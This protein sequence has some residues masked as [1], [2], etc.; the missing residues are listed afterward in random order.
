MLS[1]M[2]PWDPQ[3]YLEETRRENRS[4]QVQELALTPEQRWDLYTFVEW[5]ARPENM[6][7]R[8]DYYRDNCSTRV[9]DAL[10]QVL[11]GAIRAVAAPDTTTHT[12]R[13]HTRRLLR[14]SP[15]AYLGIQTVLGPRADRPLTAWEEAFLPR[16]LMEIVRDV[17][18]PDGEGGIRPL[19]LQ[20]RELLTTTRPPVPLNP[21]FAFPW[22]LLA[23][24]LWGGGILLLARRGLR[25]GIRG[26]AGLALLAGGWSLLAAAAGTVLLGAWLFTDHV[27]WYRNLNLLQMNPLFLLPAAAFAVFLFR[28]SLPSWAREVASALGVIAGV[29]LLAG[30]LPGIG[31]A[32]EEVLA[33]TV[34]L[35]A[36]LVLASFRLS[37]GGSR[38]SG[39][40]DPSGGAPG[41]GKE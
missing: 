7:Y 10:D 18:V 13:W 1:R 4:V 12:Y 16:R 17:Q 38:P 32:N 29:G 36:S 30:L 22:F 15:W 21:P 19:V 11:G 25:L 8:Y 26:R 39:P 28:G 35:N 23:G 5:N 6:Y 40:A 24:V 41:E 3:G 14:D 20:E 27:F 31:Q 34:P 37:G 33:L 9:R 2:A